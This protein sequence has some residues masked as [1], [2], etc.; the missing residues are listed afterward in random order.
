VKIG[1]SF[2]MAVFGMEMVDMPVRNNPK[3]LQLVTTS[4]KPKKKEARRSSCDKSRIPPGYVSFSTVEFGRCPRPALSF[5]KP[6]MGELWNGTSDWANPWR[7]L[8]SN[9]LL[10]AG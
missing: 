3:G 2:L 1:F 7:V 4:N 8:S 10:C 5:L 9:K 6:A